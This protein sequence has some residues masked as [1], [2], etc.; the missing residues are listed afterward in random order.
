MKIEFE[1][2]VYL[3]FVPPRPDT[4]V[5]A[6]I[7]DL[8]GN[9]MSTIAQ[10]QAKIEANNNLTDSAVEMIK[11]LAA[12]LEEIKNDPAAIDALIA[13]LEENNAELAAAISANTP[14]APTE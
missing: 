14:S 4:T 11:G 9:L 5:L 10:L 3:H 6:A 1:H 12:K 13:S 2:H 8:K 7:S